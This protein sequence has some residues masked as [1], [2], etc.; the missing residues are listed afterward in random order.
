MTQLPPPEHPPYTQFARRR[1][2]V[3]LGQITMMVGSIDFLTC[4]LIAGFTGAPSRAKIDRMSYWAK[5]QTLDTM[6]LTIDEPARSVVQRF[7]T[8]FRPI[9]DERNNLI[10]GFWNLPLE[11]EP[12]E[13]PVWLY[14]NG[15]RME[16][17]PEM[18]ETFSER[19]SGVLAVV[20][21]TFAALQGV[22]QWSG[23]TITGPH[24]FT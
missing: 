24:R 9:I 21:E 20:L 12:P 2:I 6:S 23:G 16:R 15:V 18:L 13:N 22:S 19:T 1:Q 11:D 3:A 14:R 7:V 5:A 10:H 4:E 8:E 17:P